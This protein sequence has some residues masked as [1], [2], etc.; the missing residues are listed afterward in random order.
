MYLYMAEY[1]VHD[2]KFGF[3]NPGIC[4]L[5]LYPAIKVTCMTHHKPSDLSR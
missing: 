5:I 2:E 3:A 4:N 1:N